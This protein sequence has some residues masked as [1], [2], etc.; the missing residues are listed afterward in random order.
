MRTL[1][2]YHRSNY[3]I[4]HESISKP[5]NIMILLLRSRPCRD[6][7]I[8]PV[9][10]IPWSLTEPLAHRSPVPWG[11][12]RSRWGNGKR[13][14]GDLLIFQVFQNLLN[15]NCILP[16]S[17]QGL[18]WT[19]YQKYPLWYWWERERE[20]ETIIYNAKIQISVFTSFSTKN[21]RKSFK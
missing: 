2:S 19:H 5:F 3:V 14:G 1:T 13:Y 9:I 10:R 6:P 12:R 17:Q 18:V 7:F 11:W 20:R 4:Y 15:L 8:R 16:W 21:I